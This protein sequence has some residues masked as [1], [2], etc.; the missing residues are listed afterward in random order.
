MEQLLEQLRPGL[1]VHCHVLTAYGLECEEDMR[2]LDEDDLAKIENTYA[3]CATPPAPLHLK[4]IMKLLA[5]AAS[6]PAGA[7]G[8]H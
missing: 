3:S 7:S 6:P 1:G 2:L 4:L 8:P 5:M